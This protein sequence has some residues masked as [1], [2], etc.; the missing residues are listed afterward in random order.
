MNAP[1]C[2][3]LLQQRLDG[4]LGPACELLEQHLA[5]CA[6]CRELHQAAGLLEEGLRA[7]PRPEPHPGLAERIVQRV[8]AERRSR[9][10]WRRR[11]LVVAA[12]A[13][14]L[15]T[16]LAVSLLADFSG[17]KSPSPQVVQRTQHKSAVIPSLEESAGE[18]GTAMAQL[19]DRLA[20]QTR[21]QVRLLWGA[22]TALEVA[23][24]VPDLETWQAPLD[25]AARSFRDAGQGVSVGFETVA[26]SARRALSYFAREVPKLDTGRRT[27]E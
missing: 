11:A 17:P 25:P 6:S 26:S 10:R 21:E 13:C 3:E 16:P 27:L 8:L 4:T 24:P 12:A 14:L 9:L 5:S 22:T 18:A 15:L 7:L 2:L 1:E 23:S 20:G 19:T